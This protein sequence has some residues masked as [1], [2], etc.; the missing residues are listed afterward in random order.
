MGILHKGWK[1][2]FARLK[3]KSLKRG[4]C[5]RGGRYARPLR[6]ESLENRELLATV[7]WH[8]DVI[9]DNDP[10]TTLREAIRDTQ[11]GGTVDFASSPTRRVERVRQK[12]R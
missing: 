5:R 1:T 12:S 6:I 2:I 8:L 7:N 9:D 3:S 11:D 4:K 10:Y